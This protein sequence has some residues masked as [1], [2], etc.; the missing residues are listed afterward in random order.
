MSESDELA[1]RLKRNE[2]LRRAMPLTRLADYG[3]SPADAV[4]I[5]HNTAADNPP[6][7]PDACEALAASHADLA[8][9]ACADGHLLAGAEEWRQAAALYLAAQLAFNLDTPEKVQLYEKARHALRAYAPLAPDAHGVRVDE[10]RLFSDQGEL[11]G[12]LVAPPGEVTATAAVII[13]GGLSG[14]GAVYLSM[15]MSLA[16]R[17]ILCL[18][19][20]GP[21]QGATRLVSGLH[22]SHGTFSLFRRFVD[23]AQQL[24][25]Q[26]IGVWGN[27]FGGLL[28]ARLAV[29]DVRVNA[30]CINGAPMR[31]ELPGFRTAREQMQAV[32][33]SNDEHDVQ[34]HLAAL[35]LD[36]SRDHI[37][38]PMLVVEGGQ[39]PL[40]PLGEQH[41]FLTLSPRQGTIMSWDD[42]EHTIYNHAAE[43]NER[44]VGWFGEVLVGPS[45]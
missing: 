19:A 21:G 25:A 44:V 36:A 5:H 13:I 27:S 23:H 42:G 18:L 31:P 8:C 9:L 43:R 33:G 7:W 29:I 14:W 20:E 10:L 40:V 1:L 35:W 16:S 30:V 37:N 28:A 34:K 15:A 17:G 24:G 11:H 6:E 2:A 39:D 32:F 4:L 38:A 12:W 22:L 3:V 41:A 26:R 45:H